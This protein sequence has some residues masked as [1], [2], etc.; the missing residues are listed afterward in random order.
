MSMIT[1]SWNKYYYGEFKTKEEAIEMCFEDNYI[2]VEDDV[3][4][5]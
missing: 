4:Y 3:F 5:F 1:K 2:T